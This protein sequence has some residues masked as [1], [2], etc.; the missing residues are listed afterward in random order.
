MVS[1]VTRLEDRPLDP[2]H[3]NDMEKL[4]S[5]VEGYI[6]DIIRLAE[7]LEGKNHDNQYNDVDFRKGQL[8]TPFSFFVASNFEVKPKEQQVC[9]FTKIS[10]HRRSDKRNLKTALTSSFLNNWKK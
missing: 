2:A 1:T 6:K 5:E 10:L 3:I 8:L 4:A 9:N 7:R